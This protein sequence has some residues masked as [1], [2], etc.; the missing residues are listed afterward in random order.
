ML[1]HT[2][3]DLQAC[4]CTFKLL[5]AR[6]STHLCCAD[7]MDRA[8]FSKAMDPETTGGMNGFVLLPA[9]EPCP[10]VV[11]APFEGVGEDL[12][13]NGVVC[14][15]YR[16]PDHQHHEPRLLPGAVEELPSVRMKVHTGWRIET[17]MCVG[18]RGRL[19]WAVWRDKLN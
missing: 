11:P 3:P 10:T 1:K 9:G 2:R 17:R 15:A 6:P 5:L 7:E 8:K 16:L 13:R 12:T 4:T 18:L 14:C 19:L